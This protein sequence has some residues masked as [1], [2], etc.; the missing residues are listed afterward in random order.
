MRNQIEPEQLL[1]LM[2][3]MGYSNVG[4]D[5][6][7]RKKQQAEYLK[8]TCRGLVYHGVTRN[9]MVKDLTSN[10]HAFYMGLSI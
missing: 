2:V 9:T 8:N 1:F 3:S 7:Q 6:D 10:V 5:D 4:N